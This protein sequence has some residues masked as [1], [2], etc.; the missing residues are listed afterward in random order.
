MSKYDVENI[1]NE[2]LLFKEKAGK[3]RYVACFG[4]T[5]VDE[6]NPNYDIS[7]KIGKLII[8]NGFGILHGGYIGTMQA[9]SSGANESIKLDPKKNEFWNIGV[10][11]KTFDADVKRADC[12]HLTATE[13]IFDRKRILV[14]MCDVCVVLPVGGMGTFLEVVELF[15]INQINSK[16]GG[17]ITP[18]IFFGKVWKELMDEIKEKL[19]LKGQSNRD[20]FTTYIDDLDQLK[21]ELKGAIPAVL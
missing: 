18:I 11:M 12:V 19:D 14:E 13:N 16:F 15:H 20:S 17:K 2:F 1:K 8:E 3:P 21:K 6:D 7:K 10:P 5:F 9:V 4:K